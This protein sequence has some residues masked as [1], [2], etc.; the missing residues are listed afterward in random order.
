MTREESKEEEG[1]D[2]GGGKRKRKR[3][4]WRMWQR[5]GEGEEADLMTV[6]DSSLHT[7]M[8]SPLF[9]RVISVVPLERGCF[10]MTSCQA[11]DI[12]RP[13]ERSY[14]LSNQKPLPPLLGGCRNDPPDPRWT[15]TQVLY[16]LPLCRA[17]L[18]QTGR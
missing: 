8:S 14:S 1:G 9:I 11:T 16:P 10:Q 13:S 15:L 6:C 4:R 2:R 18:L 7:V 17:A 3:K 5:M 12:S